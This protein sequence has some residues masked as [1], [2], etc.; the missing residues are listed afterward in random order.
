MPNDLENAGLVLCWGGPLEKFNRCVFYLAVR[1]FVITR[2]DS[3]SKNM[4]IN[5][6]RRK[7]ATYRFFAETKKGKD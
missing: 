6:F 4:Q 2:Q 5:F 3:D 7:S 1:S